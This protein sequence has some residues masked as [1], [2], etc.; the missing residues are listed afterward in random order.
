VPVALED[1]LREKADATVADTHGGWGEAVDVFPV[2]E[3]VLQL[4]F[5]EQVRRFAIELRQQADFPDIGLLGALTLAAEL[6]RSNHALTQWGH[7]VS[8]FVS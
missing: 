7:E 4:L 3:V 1:V 2:Q 8:P 6:K 5:G